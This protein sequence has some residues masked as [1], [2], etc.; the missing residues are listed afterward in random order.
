MQRHIVH[1]RISQ[2][3]K[4]SSLFFRAMHQRKVKQ[5][6]QITSEWTGRT[7]FIAE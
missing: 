5:D 3:P 7:N 6:L 2:P 1:L 4:F